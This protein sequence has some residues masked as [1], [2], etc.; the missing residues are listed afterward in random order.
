LSIHWVSLVICFTS[1]TER[2]KQEVGEVMV[3][4]AIGGVK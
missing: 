3:K 2:E 4:K 1:S